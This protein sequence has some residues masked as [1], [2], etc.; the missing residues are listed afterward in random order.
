MNNLIKGACRGLGLVIFPSHWC[1]YVNKNS[2]KGPINYSLT[3]LHKVK[4]ISEYLL[5]CMI[6]CIFYNN[7][8]FRDL[9]F[10]NK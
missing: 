9:K 5:F 2:I 10:Y 3:T 6:E 7:H 8:L 1:V 4:T